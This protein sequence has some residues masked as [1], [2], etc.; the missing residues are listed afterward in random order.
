MRVTVMIVSFALVLS[1]A[2]NEPRAVASS[3]VQEPASGNAPAGVCGLDVTGPRADAVFFALGMAREQGG[4]PIDTRSPQLEYFYCDEQPASV[5]FRR[6]VT[7][8]ALEQGLPAD[9]REE[10]VQG[11]LI[12]TSSPSIA[13]GLNAC[14]QPKEQPGRPPVYGLDLALFARRGAAAQGQ[15]SLSSNQLERRRAL[16]YVAGA[17]ARFHRGQAIVLAAG[18]AKADLLAALLKALGCANVSVESTVDTIP[19]ASTVHFEPTPEV[20]AWINKAW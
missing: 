16:A 4:R 6:V 19:G 2:A 9:F 3:A 5:V 7:R 11:C 8:L 12:A 10:T 18:D 13:P 1:C 15:A 14:Y 17:W 20:T